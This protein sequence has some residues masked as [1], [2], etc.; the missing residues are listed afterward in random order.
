MALSKHAALCTTSR[1]YVKYITAVMLIAFLQLEK[2][3]EA[4]EIDCDELL[5]GDEDD[6][7]DWHA[8]TWDYST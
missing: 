3:Q 7:A 6:G 5:V 1:T 8:M 2:D 4:E